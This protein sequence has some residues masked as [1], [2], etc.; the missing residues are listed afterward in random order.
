MNIL[1]LILISVI[2]IGNIVFLVH[3]AGLYPFLRE[4]RRPRITF[5]TF[6]SKFQAEKMNTH[7]YQVHTGWNDFLRRHLRKKLYDSKDP[8]SALDKVINQY[9]EDPSEKNHDTM[10]HLSNHISNRVRYDD[11][12]D[13]LIEKISVLTFNNP[14]KA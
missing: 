11:Q 4:A 9:L 1:L 10:V 12:I 14:T 2:L 5:F 7:G 3:Y 13:A 6:P 8:A